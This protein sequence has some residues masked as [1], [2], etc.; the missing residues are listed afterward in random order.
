MP[1]RCAIGG[2]VFFSWTGG[3]HDVVLMRDQQAYEQCDFE[4]STT[5]ADVGQAGSAQSYSYVCTE[6]GET[7]FLSCS[8][9]GHCLSGQKVEVHTSSSVSVDDASSSMAA[10]HAQS[11]R[12]VMT[13]LNHPYMNTGYATEAQANATLEAIWCLKVHCPQSAQDWDAVATTASCKAD[14]HNLA[15]FVSRSRPR[16]QFQ[17]AERYYHEALEFEPHHCPSLEY[18]IE[19]YLAVGNATAAV[20]TALRLCSSCGLE[21]PEAQLAQAAFSGAAFDVSFPLAECIAMTPPPPPLPPPSPP[22]LPP[23]PPSAPISSSSLPA[24]AIAG[25]CVGAMAVLFVAAFVAFYKC[26]RKKNKAAPKNKE[27]ATTSGLPHIEQTPVA[28]FGAGSA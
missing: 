15:G 23:P 22:P 13:V 27:I 19:L 1:V 5:L 26:F 18:L 25:I 16:P 10:V 11:L 2:F 20:S 7:A 9:P 12:D 4:G 3:Q 28:S 17:H 6:P 8:I 24:G 21:A 14:V